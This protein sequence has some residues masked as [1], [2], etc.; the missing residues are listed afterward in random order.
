[1]SNHQFILLDK[2]Y[3]EELEKVADHSRFPLLRYDQSQHGRDI[4]KLLNE[5]ERMNYLLQRLA[6]QYQAEKWEMIDQIRQLNKELAELR[7]KTGKPR[8][9]VKSTAIDNRN[10]AME[11]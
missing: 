3:I 1:M 11:D 6:D 10:F 4:S 2:T 7:K 8:R 5:L 9:I